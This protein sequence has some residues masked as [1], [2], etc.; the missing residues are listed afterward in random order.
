MGNTL[1]SYGVLINK[2]I[3][4]LRSTCEYTDDELTQHS[5]PIARTPGSGRGRKRQSEV[6]END[7]DEEVKT[8]SKKLKTPGKASPT[9]VKMVA[10]AP[11]IFNPVVSTFKTWSSVDVTFDDEGKPEGTLALKEIE[12]KGHGY[13]F[14]IEEV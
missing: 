7:D 6:Y 12:G 1:E 11:P 8:P 13:D 5:A 10:V 2:G 4:D 9:K 14:S 3:K